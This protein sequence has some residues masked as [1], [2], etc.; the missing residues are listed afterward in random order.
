M[1]N[2]LAECEEQN[3]YKPPQPSGK[4]IQDRNDSTWQGL[5]RLNKGLKILELTWSAKITVEIKY[6]IVFQTRNLYSLYKRYIKKAYRGIQV[7]L[8]DI[9]TIG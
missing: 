9:M 2:A 8:P 7:N 5:K 1:A 6:K 3:P 4:C